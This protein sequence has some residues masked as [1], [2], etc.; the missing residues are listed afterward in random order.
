[1]Y[2]EVMF[3]ECDRVE[4]NQVSVYTLHWNLADQALNSGIIVLDVRTHSMG[5]GVG[6][7]PFAMPRSLIDAQRDG[8]H[9]EFWLMDRYQEYLI[10]TQTTHRRAW[11]Q[12]LSIS[13]I[14]IACDNPRD[15]VKAHR[16]VLRNV[17]TEYFYANGKTVEHMGEVFRSLTS[18]V[19]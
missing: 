15:S 19:A 11:E 3:Q 4:D 10:S 8:G 17:L 7:V 1:M 5:G 13:S 14:G 2:Q 9:D 18:A 16:M 6:V 12:L